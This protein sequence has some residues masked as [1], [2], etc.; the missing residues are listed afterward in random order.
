MPSFDKKIK[1]LSLSYNKN[2][3]Y[4]LIY[5]NTFRHMKK[6]ILKS[7]IE[8]KRD[9]ESFYF[10]VYFPIVVDGLQTNEK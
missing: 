7:P 2:G 4:T 8:G 3:T 1:I 9:F 10:N 6:A 5:E